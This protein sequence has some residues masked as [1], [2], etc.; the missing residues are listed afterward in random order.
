MDGKYLTLLPSE[1]KSAHLFQRG[2]HVQQ[3]VAR[4]DVVGAEHFQLLVSPR[5]NH[6]SLPGY[7]DG[8]GVEALVEM[9]AIGVHVDPLQCAEMLH[10]QHVLGVYGVRHER[11]GADASFEPVPVDVREDV[12]AV[13]IS[14]IYPV[15]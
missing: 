11:M 4:R 2:W 3:E 13:K 7:Q 15:W 5:L 1:A 9:V 12:M 10:A 14:S 8:A 6:L